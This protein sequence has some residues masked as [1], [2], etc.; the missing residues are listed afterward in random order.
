MT[1]YNRVLRTLIPLAA[2]TIIAAV[3]LYFLINSTGLH[4]D[5]VISIIF[6]VIILSFI[7]PL[8]SDGYQR[9]EIS[10]KSAHPH[11]KTRIK[12]EFSGTHRFQEKDQETIILEKREH[13]LLAWFYLGRRN[14]W[15]SISS[16][17]IIFYGPAETTARI[18]ALIFY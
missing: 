5:A 14:T 4:T 8:V 3:V 7:I 10:A 18:T 15:I 13:P 2:I 16:S 17:Q 11:W 12:N 9:K 6:I 1:Y